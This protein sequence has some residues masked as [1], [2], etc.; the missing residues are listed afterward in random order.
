MVLPS[1]SN[2]TPVAP[3]RGRPP[4]RWAQGVQ[5]ARHGEMPFLHAVVAPSTSRSKLVGLRRACPATASV[6]SVCFPL[7]TTVARGPGERPPN[8]DKSV[9][10]TLAPANPQSPGVEP[11]RC[12]QPLSAQFARS[13][14]PVEPPPP[15]PAAAERRSV[16]GRNAGPTL[17]AS[18]D[19]SRKQQ[20]PV[21]LAQYKSSLARGGSPPGAAGRE[22]AGRPGA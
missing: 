16:R 3:P 6:T 17:P 9:R 12:G 15:L 18:P 21:R 10:V 1:A 19:A 13:C 22:I 20:P 14:E 11:F 4:W 7:A 8:C 5:S 2:P